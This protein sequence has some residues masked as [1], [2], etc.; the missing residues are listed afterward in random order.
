MLSKKRVVI[1]LV[2]AGYMYFLLPATATFFYELYHLTGIDSV[3]WGYSIFKAAGYYF[4]VWP[5]QL[6]A[7]IAVAAIIIFL[8]VVWQRGGAKT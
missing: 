8:P 3:Y 2:L 4:S 5:Y 1:G 7:C 6:Q